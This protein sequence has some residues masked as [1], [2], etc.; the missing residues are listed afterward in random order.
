MLLASLAA[1][2][3]FTVL[4]WVDSHTWIYIRKRWVCVYVQ[5]SNGDAT[6]IQSMI[7]GDF[8]LEEITIKSTSKTRI[9]RHR[10]LRRR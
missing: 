10:Q 4:V 9:Y 1:G 6:Y 3:F 2:L 7:N 5:R 8:V